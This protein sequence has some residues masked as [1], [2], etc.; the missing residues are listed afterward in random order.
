M[1]LLKIL[2]IPL[3][4]TESLLYLWVNQDNQS[5]RDSLIGVILSAYEKVF[6]DEFDML[7]DPPT[8]M[9]DGSEEPLKPMN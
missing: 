9:D 2:I 6:I 8:E 1:F 4:Q 7:Q 3:N 5:L